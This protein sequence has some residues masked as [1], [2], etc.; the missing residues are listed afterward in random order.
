MLHLYKAGHNIKCKHAEANWLVWSKC[1]S[2][3]FLSQLFHSIF[4]LSANMIG[5]KKQD[6]SSHEEI[7]IKRDPIIAP[8]S[9]VFKLAIFCGYL[10]YEIPIDHNRPIS[11][12]SYGLI[13]AIFSLLSILFWLILWIYEAIALTLPGW[14]AGKMNYIGVITWSIF[15]SVLI[16]LVRIQKLSQITKFTKFWLHY[17]S[18]QQSLQYLAQSHGKNKE[19]Q[20]AVLNTHKNC[21][22]TILSLAILGVIQIGG[23]CICMYAIDAM[24]RNSFFHET[25]YFTWDITQCTHLVSPCVLL[26]FARS[27]A[28]SFQ[29]IGNLICESNMDEDSKD[30][31]SFQIKPCQ[32]SGP[33]K[34]QL[35]EKHYVSTIG[36]QKLKE[37]LNAFRELEKVVTEFNLLHDWEILAAVLF[38]S[39]QLL[40]C[41][42]MSFGMRGLEST[43]FIANIFLCSLSAGIFAYTL[44]QL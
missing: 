44:H 11:S 30:S 32:I 36:D 38:I 2:S 18:F 40:L 41:L 10:P 27:F 6:N 20:T 14:G 1:F 12:C 16:I 19:Y 29:L 7:S 25:L 37:T 9:T 24:N 13:F 35:A 22:R 17:K 39:I 21:N 42:Y 15:G 4:K 33:K 23:N 34:I 8:N 26:C 3:L 5:I 31:H 28:S 43:V